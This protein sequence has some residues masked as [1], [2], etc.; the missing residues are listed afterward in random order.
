MH[1]YRTVTYTIVGVQA[2]YHIGQKHN[3]HKENRRD[4]IMELKY[5]ICEHCGNIITKLK[6]SKVPVMCCGQKMNE[7]VVE[8]LMRLLKNMC[9]FTK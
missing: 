9:R 5:Y 6:D 1:N 3:L 4:R 2:K 7:L 8:Q